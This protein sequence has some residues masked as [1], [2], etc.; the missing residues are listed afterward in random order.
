MAR[1]TSS[2]KRIRFS[3]E[4]AVFIGAL[5]GQWRDEAR[6]QIAVRGMQLDHVEARAAAALH[7]CTKSAITASMS[8]RVISRGTWLLG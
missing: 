7:A 3:S 6:Q 1:N 4:T 5:V 2:G 8:A